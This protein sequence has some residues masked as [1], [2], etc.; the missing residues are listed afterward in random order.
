[1]G[2]VGSGRRWRFDGR[3]TV[4]AYRQLD[5]RKLARGGWL[6]PGLSSTLTW[7]RGGAEVGRIEIRAEAGRI[8]LDYR[9]RGGSG[10]WEMMNYPVPLV[11]TPCHLGGAR[12][13]FLC[14][15]RGCGRR[16]AVL[17]GGRIFAC[18]RCHG[19]AYPSQREDAG[20]RAARKADR[21]R[22]RLGWPGGVLDGSDLG[23]PKGMHRETYA[24]LCAEH[25]ALRETW[26]WQFVE[27]WRGMAL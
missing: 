21:L 24:R 26:E 2:G 5:V 19:L 9:V 7:T 4:D 20:D 11:S 14:P 13:W 25:D 8:V 1:M 23:R 12:R 22:E 6:E 27:R 10:D 3:D 18:R 16:V 15:A 17:Y